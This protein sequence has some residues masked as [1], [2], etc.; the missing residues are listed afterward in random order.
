MNATEDVNWLDMPSVLY[1]TAERLQAVEATGLNAGLDIH[2]HSHNP[3]TKQLAKAL[4]P[5]GPLF[6]EEPILVDHPEALTQL[7]NMTSIP[8]ALDERLCHRWDA[9]IFLREG[10][11][12]M[13]QPVL[14]M[15]EGFQ[16]PN[17]SRTRR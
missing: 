12:D 13:L 14:C 5:H 6:T 3:T 4:E 10:L 8:I 9:K 15:Q 1:S 7:A 2:G 17:V 16:K 11:I